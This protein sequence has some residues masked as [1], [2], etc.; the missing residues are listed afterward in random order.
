MYWSITDL[1]CQFCLQQS[2]SVIHIQ[3]STLFQILFPCRSNRVWSIAPC[4]IQQVLQ[5]SSVAQSCPTTCDPM[6]CST[7]GFPVYHQLPEL[8]QTH[9]H[10][11]SDAIQPSHPLL[12][13]SIFPS[14]RV[15]SNE[16]VLHIRW[17]VYWSYQLQDQFFQ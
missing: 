1:Q 12:S 16:S 11:V 15:S 13:P 10:R 14:I 5:L 6:D 2:E 3:T 9:I 4:I 7:S 8:A 17:P